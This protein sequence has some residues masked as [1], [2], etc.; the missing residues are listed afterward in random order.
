MI[1]E[2]EIQGF[3]QWRNSVISQITFMLV[4]WC[5][6]TL[7]STFFERHRQANEAAWSRGEEALAV[8]ITIV[9]VEREH[10]DIVEL[11]E[12]EQ[13]QHDCAETFLDRETD[14]VEAWKQDCLDND[15]I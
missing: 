7:S 10:A 5:D 9:N 4:D 3:D 1:E 6:P 11:Q 2:F 14:L 15:L 13:S 12:R 8:A